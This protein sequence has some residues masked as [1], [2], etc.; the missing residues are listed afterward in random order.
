ME[1]NKLYRKCGHCGIVGVAKE[2]VF[3][4][5]DPWAFEVEEVDRREWQHEE[6]TKA[7]F[8]DV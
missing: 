7:S 6:C 4:V 5:S 2:E 1:K 3:W 8:Y